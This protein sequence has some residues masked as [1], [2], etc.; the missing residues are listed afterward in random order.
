MKQPKIINTQPS[1][2]DLLD[3]HKKDIFFTMNCHAI[4]TIQSF[5]KETQTCVAKINY[6]KMFFERQTDG[7]YRQVPK[8]YPI[9]TDVPVV[10]LSGG[11]SGLTLPVKAGDQALIMFNDRDFGN[12][13]EG[14]S[15]GFV[16]SLRM[17]SMSDGIALVG[18]FRKTNR[19]ANFDELNPNLFNEDAGVR[20]LPT[21]VEFYNSTDSLGPLLQDLI[22]QVKDLVTQTSAITVI[23][24]S[25]GNPSSTP[26]NL[27]AINAITGQ[28]TTTATKLSGLLE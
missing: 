15:S 27:A 25:P 24:A 6:D 21:K 16:P 13:F 9:L 10:F 26:V 14:A 22:N 17:H 12:W 7:S 23:C 19:L 28:L 8:P 11:L 3:A 1:L 2:K 18:L 4:A 5:D 20:V